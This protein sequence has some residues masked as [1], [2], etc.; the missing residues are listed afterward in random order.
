MISVGLRRIASGCKWVN[1]FLD[2]R[3]ILLSG[4]A[5][6]VFALKVEPKLCIDGGRGLTIG[7]VDN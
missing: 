2:L 5:K 3:E 1:L 7:A 4:E 6:V